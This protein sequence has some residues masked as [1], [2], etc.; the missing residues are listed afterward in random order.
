[1]YQTMSSNV[2]QPQC[3]KINKCPSTSVV[4][5]HFSA[6]SLRSGV[7]KNRAAKW[8]SNWSRQSGGL[9]G[10]F[11]FVFDTSNSHGFWRRL[12]PPSC[13]SSG[14]R[15]GEGRCCLSCLALWADLP[16]H[17]VALFILNRG[18]LCRWCTSIGPNPLSPVSS[19][20]GGSSSVKDAYLGSDS[21]LNIL[22]DVL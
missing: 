18:S 2:E 5:M 1:M 16:L 17:H 15:C 20:R 8:M 3:K 9:F 10:S 4:L 22:S 21:P 11:G 7:P 6:K 12:E 13:K 19:L 14:I